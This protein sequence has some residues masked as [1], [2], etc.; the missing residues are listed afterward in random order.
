MRNKD[1]DYDYDDDDDDDDDDSHAQAVTPCWTSKRRAVAHRR[2]DRNSDRWRR[3][4]WR[5]NRWDRKSDRKRAATT[6]PAQPAQK[7]CR[8]HERRSP[9]RKSRE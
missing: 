8:P 5:R 9:R 6:Q 7:K 4:R 2:V 1:D 3:K